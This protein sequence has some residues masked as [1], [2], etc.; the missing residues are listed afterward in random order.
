MRLLIAGE[1][2]DGSE[3]SGSFDATLSYD[4]GHD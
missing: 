2:A 1:L 3:L 4:P